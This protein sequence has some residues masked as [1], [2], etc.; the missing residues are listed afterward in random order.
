M[1]L[2][3]FIPA[4]VNVSSS[5]FAV[6]DLV[7][8]PYGDQLRPDPQDDPFLQDQGAVLRPCVLLISVVERAPAEAPVLLSVLAEHEKGERDLHRGDI[9]LTQVLLQ[10]SATDARQAFV[11]G[12]RGRVP[13]PA[14]EDGTNRFRRLWR[15]HAAL[16]LVAFFFAVVVVAAAVLR[17]FG[18]VGVG[19]AD[20][21]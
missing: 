17:D 2:A 5:A 10:D 16:D 8:A 11:D 14:D 18:S 6:A 12:L 15:L 4:S 3:L 19:R 13:R 21:E 20:L 9:G 7:L 1:C